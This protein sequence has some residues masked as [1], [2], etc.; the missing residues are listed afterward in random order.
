MESINTLADMTESPLEAPEVL[1]RRLKDAL[2]KARENADLTQKAVAQQLDWSPSKIIRIEQGAV[3]VSSTD[4]RALLRLYGVD[5]ESQV[6]ELTELAKR[7]RKQSWSEYKD[8]YSQVSLTLFAY[9]SA[10]KRI[11]N[12]EPTFIPGLLQTEEY[13]QAL[14][15]GLGHSEERVDL[16]V[17]ARLARQ[18]LLERSPRPELSFILG[19]GS[20]S[21]PIGGKRVML[22]QLDRLKELASLPGIKIQVLTF[23]VGV[24][25]SMGA[26]FTILEFD[27]L[28]DLLYLESSTGDHIYRDDPDLISKY[29][30]NFATLESLATSP[31]ELSPALDKISKRRFG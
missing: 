4:V 21:R 22:H 10:A 11:L 12:Y 20:V 9:E 24:H 27:G 29:R 5:D 19:E 18:E 1:R 26:A 15:R 6:R 8:V 7:S 3:G 31:D 2:R 13:A 28:D 16:K 23:D 25:P 14:L 17:R 30:E